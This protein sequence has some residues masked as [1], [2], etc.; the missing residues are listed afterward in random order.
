MAPVTEVPRR[1]LDA[2]HLMAQLRRQEIVARV[3]ELGRLGAEVTALEAE[4]AQLARRIAE[5]THITS[6]EAAPYLGEFIRSVRSRISVLE[7]RAEALRPR[8]AAL[9]AE[10]ASLFREK[11]SYDSVR[12]AGIAANLQAREKRAEDEA[13]DMVLMRWAFRDGA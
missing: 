11:R 9:D 12:L 5:E 6:L 4:K 13:A 7:T 3:Q 10:V 2:L 8:L 1:R